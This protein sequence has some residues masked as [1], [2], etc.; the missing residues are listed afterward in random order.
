MI[1]VWLFLSDSAAAYQS[2]TRN[3]TR[4]AVALDRAME[5]EVRKG[6][7]GAVLVARGKAIML[8]RAYGSI[9]GIP[10]RTGTRF[11]IASAAKQFVSASILKCVERGLLNL[12]DPISKF[13]PD[14]PTEKRTISVE[15]LLAHL[16]GLDQSYV[17]EGLS[18]RETAVKRMFG[19]SLIDK[20]GAKF[21]YSNSNYQLAVAIVEV[22]SG[23]SYRKF[24]AEELWQP[25]GLRNTGFSGDARARLVGPAIG[26]T[27]A[28]LT[29][30]SWGGE[31]VYSTTSDLL[32]WYRVLQSGLLLSTASVKRLFDGVVP[33]GEGKGTLG[34]FIGRTEKGATRIFTRGNEGFGANGLIYA[35]PETDTVII[36][37]SHAGQVNDDLSWSRLAHAKIEKLLSL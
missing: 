4:L 27:P 21:H 9:R 17:S 24:V 5:E 34:W 36:V 37:L 20:P 12:S 26:D 10:V 30:P 13:F 11:W 14:A 18:D 22:V 16:S 31:G 32:K 33:I 23:R 15:Q 25:A 7:S 3:E 6:F 2:S 1:I 28:R 29:K 35:Y 8:D 19:E